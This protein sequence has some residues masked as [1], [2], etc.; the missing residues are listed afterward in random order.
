MFDVAVLCMFVA[1]LALV[2]G[3]V[4][5]LIIADRV[6]LW[7]PQDTDVSPG[8]VRLWIDLEPK[9]HRFLRDAAQRHSMDVTTYLL[10]KALGPG[11]VTTVV[12]DIIPA[13][14]EQ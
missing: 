8:K 14:R 13:P 11:T 10:S 7:R 4:L 3:A 1:M 6:L 12:G 2:T 9:L 5:G